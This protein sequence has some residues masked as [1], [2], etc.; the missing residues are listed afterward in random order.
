M[1]WLKPEF[2]TSLS[3]PYDPGGSLRIAN[4]NFHLLVEDKMTGVFYSLSGGE[5]TV[6]VIKHDVVF[7]S[8]S[9]STLFIPGPTTFSPFTLSRGFADYV[10]LYD[11]L[12]YASNGDIIRARRNGTI[13]M[14]HNATQDDVDSG[15]ANAVGDWIT[16]LQWHFYNAWP[17]K[18]A[19]FGSFM[20]EGTT[21]TIAR[22][23]LTLVAETIEYERFT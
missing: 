1:A 15:K 16:V 23:S 13:K 7:E 5:I 11:W 10:Q 3:G 9:S 6:G 8:G 2:T 14:Y 19:S 20:N 4:C 18:L 22:V 17:T 21:T 12:M